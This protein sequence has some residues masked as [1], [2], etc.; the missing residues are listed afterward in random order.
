[1]G[2]ALAR[3]AATVVLTLLIKEGV[4]LTGHWIAWW[5]AAVIALVLVFGRAPAPRLRRHHQRLA[6]MALSWGAAASAPQLPA[7]PPC[8]S[9]RCASSPPP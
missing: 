1:M 3:L 8:R 7:S 6:L 5:L 9:A 4:A 2:E